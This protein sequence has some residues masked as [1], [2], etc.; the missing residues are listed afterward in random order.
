[1]GVHSS[2]IH[3]RLGE[4]TD[5]ECLD[6]M[7]RIQLISES[8]PSHGR[9]NSMNASVPLST[10]CGKVVLLPHI[11]VSKITC[12]RLPLLKLVKGAAGVLYGSITGILYT[13]HPVLF[14]VLSS[15]QWLGCGATYSL[16]REILLYQTH[17][18]ARSKPV[19][20]AVAASATGAGLAALMRKRASIRPAAM[21]WAVAGFAGQMAVDLFSNR[22]RDTPTVEKP[23]SSIWDS[24]WSP[25]KRVTGGCQTCCHGIRLLT[26]DR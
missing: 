1:M 25:L 23:K 19:V 12:S 13:Q 17:H 6:V 24:S 15:T 5:A 16:I 9:M 2:D 18:D 8:T 14:T 7:Y 22:L 11:R 3:G 26:M 10:R 4:Y 21:V 20:S